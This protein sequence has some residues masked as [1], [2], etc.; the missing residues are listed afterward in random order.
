MGDSWLRLLA[1]KSLGTLMRF[2]PFETTGQRPEIPR[3]LTGAARPVGTKK[4]TCVTFI[5]K[6][7]Y[8]N[9]RGRAVPGAGR[10]R[11][12][13]SAA[14]MRNGRL[15]W[16]AGICSSFRGPQH[17]RLPPAGVGFPQL[18]PEAGVGAGMQMRGQPRRGTL[19]PGSGGPFMLRRTL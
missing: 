7:G 6:E 12:L 16:E 8:T 2:V 13:L 19:A 5:G 3:S 17:G 9:R 15:C 11:G 4:R 18:R 14:I 1:N 10:A